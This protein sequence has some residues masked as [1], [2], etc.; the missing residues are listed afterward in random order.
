MLF[1][2]TFTP[3]STENEALLTLTAVRAQDVDAAA[4]LAVSSPFTFIN[5]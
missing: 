4:S 5:V 3:V 1:V 2:L